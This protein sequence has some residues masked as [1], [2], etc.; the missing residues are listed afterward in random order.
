LVDAVVPHNGRKHGISGRQLFVAR[1][2][3]VRT[4]NNRLVNWKHL[5]HHGEQR[6]ES[7][8]NRIPAVN[9][10]LTMQDFLIL[11]GIGDHSL[12]IGN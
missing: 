7:R 9:G 6:V 2:K 5:I 11:L 4:I 1:D 12:A 8:L 3:F 10:N